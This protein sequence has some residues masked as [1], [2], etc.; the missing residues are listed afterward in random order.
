MTDPLLSIEDMMKL[1]GLSRGALA[2]MRYEGKGPRFTKIT[3]KVVRY[4]QS[5]YEKWLEERTFR[6]T[7]SGSTP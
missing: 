1:T 6:S 5:E 2:T 3:G 4:R 7:A